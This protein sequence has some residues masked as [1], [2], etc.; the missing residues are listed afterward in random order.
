MEQKEN[1]SYEERMKERR[2]LI[3]EMDFVKTKVK[4]WNRKIEEIKNQI[5]ILEK[6]LENTQSEKSEFE[7]QL[8]ELEKTYIE[9]GSPVPEEEGYEILNGLLGMKRDINLKLTEHLNDDKI[10]QVLFYFILFYFIYLV[11][12]NE[13]RIFY[14]EKSFSFQ[15]YD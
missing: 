11:I 2:R 8:R 7:K 3:S 14:L 5:E 4:D 12:W 6:E 1:M 13:L 10:R 15:D 9:N